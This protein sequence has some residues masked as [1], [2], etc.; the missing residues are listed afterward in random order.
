LCEVGDFGLSVGLQKKLEEAC[1]S[2]GE[3]MAWDDEYIV[4][5]ENCDHNIN[6]S[7]KE[8]SLKRLDVIYEKLGRKFGASML[9]QVSERQSLRPGFS[10][11]RLLAYLLASCVHMISLLFLVGSI[12]CIVNW[13]GRFWFVLFGLF[14]LGLSWVTRPRFGKL[15]KHETIVSREE[16]PAL[17]KIVDDLCGAAG[18]RPID[19]IIIDQQ[20]NASVTTIGLRG[21]KILTI[22]LPLFTILP[23]EER[24]A[25]LGH[26]VGHI[27]N[28]D[29]GRSVFVGGAIT[30]LTTWYLIGCA[31]GR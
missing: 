14:L 2:C 25:L 31:N 16:H 9:H 15:E 29:L 28:R 13:D 3:M 21:K 11:P 20:F 12:Y 23:K 17:Y 24:L 4:W 30:T 7:C 22:G 18:V 27:A 8:E 19:G 6:P 26:E 1:P 5:C 10:L